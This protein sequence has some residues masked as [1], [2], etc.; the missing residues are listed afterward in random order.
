MICI[1]TKAAMLVSVSVGMIC[2]F[3]LLSRI[4]FL[5]I[6]FPSSNSF[7]LLLT[8]ILSNVVRFLSLKKQTSKNK[9]KSTKTWKT[10]QAHTQTHG[11]CC[12]LSSYFWACPKVWLICHCH[13][14]RENR[15]SLPQQV[16][17]ANTFLARGGTLCPCLFHAG[18]LTGLKLCGQNQCEPSPSFFFF[19]FFF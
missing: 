6:F 7:Q 5:I 10:K 9:N 18:I 12:V 17:I 8:S 2:L 3:N 19:F 13:S 1:H 15:F 16:S 11:L 14:R 4:Y